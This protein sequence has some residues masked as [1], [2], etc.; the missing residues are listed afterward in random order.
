MTFIKGNTIRNT[1]KTRFK[2]GL[3]PWNKGKKTGIVPKT[4]FKKNDPRL[5]GKAHHLWK[6]DR[7]G[8]VGLHLWVRRRLGKPKL[9]KHCILEGKINTHNIQWCNKSHKY[10]RDLRDWLELCRPHHMKYDHILGKAWVTR[11]KERI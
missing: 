11:R 9:C 5:M 8:N 1:G 10:K 3:I 6:G 7:V 4:A 2:K